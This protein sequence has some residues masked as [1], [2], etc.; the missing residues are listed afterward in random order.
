MRPTQ[1]VFESFLEINFKTIFF[2]FERTHILLMASV[3]QSAIFSEPVTLTFSNFLKLYSCWL[4]K[5]K[6]YAFLSRIGSVDTLVAHMPF[7]K[8]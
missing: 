5:E 1:E 3:S 6:P 2:F 7:E 8:R 4:G